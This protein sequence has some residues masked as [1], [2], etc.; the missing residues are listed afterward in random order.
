MF[1]NTLLACAVALP[2]G[3]IGGIPSATADDVDIYI[4]VPAHDYQVSPR[5][6][7]YKGYGRNDA[8]RYR[9]FHGGY[10]DYNNYDDEDY[11]D[12]RPR[13]VSCRE[14]R[15]LVRSHGF[16]HVE[17][18]ECAGRNYTFSGFRNGHYMIIYVNSHT[19]RVWKT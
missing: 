12:A 6:R 11:A 1:K 18:R 13:R 5:Y 15:R 19:G 4:G 7:H 9:R 16:R 14:A 2:L 10:G 8:Q 17:T 3:V